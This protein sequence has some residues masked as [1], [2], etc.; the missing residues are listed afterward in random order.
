MRVRVM[1]KGDMQIGDGSL[2]SAITVFTVGIFCL[3]EAMPDI[4]KEQS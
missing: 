2:C 1:Q 4:L 3:L